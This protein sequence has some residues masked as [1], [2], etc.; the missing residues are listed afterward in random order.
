MVKGKSVDQLEFQA[1]LPLSVFVEKY[2]KQNPNQQIH[3]RNE[4]YQQW[5]EQESEA[6]KL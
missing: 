5:T 3:F 4:E 1:W 2:H 6:A